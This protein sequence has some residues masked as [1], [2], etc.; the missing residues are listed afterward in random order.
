M[1]QLDG[2]VAIVTGGARGIGAGIATVMAAQGAKVG[3]L[4]LDGETAAS[5][6]SGLAV[7]GIGMACD[8]ILEEP[9]A[10][11]VKQIVDQFGGLD[12]FVNNAGA[13]RMP[14]D[15]AI[16]P[17]SG[18]L[19]V[20]NMGADG[21]D[22]QLA[23]N[24]RSTFLG[25]KVAVPY[26]RARGGGSIVNIASIAGLSASPTLPAYAAAKA[27]VIS[28][29]RSSALEYAPANIR[30]NAICPGFLWTRAW[31]G[32]AAGM[33][34]NV[35]RYKDAD[36]RDIFLEVVQNGVPLR[37]EQTPEDIGHLAAFLSSPAAMNITGQAISV[38]GGITL[39]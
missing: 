35:P 29:S 34:M 4:D 32:L 38:D 26:L 31:Q 10:S 20:E 33:K 14:L 8:V 28:L 39:R 5:T 27:G 21:W 6:A 12:I 7:P 1:G 25:T 17:A 22:Q 9:L 24:L 11:A 23:Q 18:G 19:R 15:P 13:G 2:M 36:P 30:V 37:G 3:I 16:T